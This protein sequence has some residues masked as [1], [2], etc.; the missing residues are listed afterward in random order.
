MI[1]QLLI[2]I[3][4]ILLIIIIVWGICKDVKDS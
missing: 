2:D 4:N 1:E 3:F